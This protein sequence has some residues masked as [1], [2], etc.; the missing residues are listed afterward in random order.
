[1]STCAHI[2]PFLIFYSYFITADNVFVWNISDD[3]LVFHGN[4]FSHN[5]V[6][7]AQLFHTTV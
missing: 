7:C 6:S 4:V 3:K 5:R 1:M 2:L